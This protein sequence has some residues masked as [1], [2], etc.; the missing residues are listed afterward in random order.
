MPFWR[1]SKQTSENPD[2]QWLEEIAP[3][4]RAAQAQ[5]Q[6]LLV[7][8]EDLVAQLERLLFRHD[9]VG[10]NFGEN[11]DEYRPEVETITLRLPEVTNEADLLRIIHEEFVR[12]H[13]IDVAGRPSRYEGIA[14]EIWAVLGEAREPIRAAEKLLP[15][16]AIDGSRF[17]D[18]E[19]FYREVSEHLIPGAE[20]G[21]NLDAF[22]DILR[23]GFGTPEGG[24]ELRW[25]NSA[26]SRSALGWPATIAR[27]ERLL[28]TC[29]PDNRTH[30]QHLLDE[31]RRHRGQTLFDLIVEIIQNHGPGGDEAG[32]GVVL[33]LA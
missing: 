18:L 11:V 26:T 30:V 24:F 4:V 27:Y 31:A 33:L 32:N 12:W 3:R 8:Q 23:G 5:R 16:L 22:N 15:T 17:S 13:D 2:R 28:Q 7:G 10:L 6:R 29:H 21:R 20:W 14:S 19:G 25:L 1:R 9:P